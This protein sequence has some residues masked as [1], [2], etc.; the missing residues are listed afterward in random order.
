MNERNKKVYA[1]VIAVL[2]VLSIS[3]SFLP[4][5]PVIAS[6]NYSRV[7]IKSILD[8]AFYDALPSPDDLFSYTDLQ[9]NISAKINQDSSLEGVLK[10]VNYS[11]IRSY[12]ANFDEDTRIVQYTEWYNNHS[13]NTILNFSNDVIF[14]N[15]QD[16]FDRVKQI[17]VVIT[18]TDNACDLNWYL[19]L[20]DIY[21]GALGFSNPQ[22]Y[23]K[24]S[25]RLNGNNYNTDITVEMPYDYYSSQGTWF[26]P[27]ITSA[28]ISP[29]YTIYS[30][31]KIYLPY[32]ANFTSDPNI[33]SYDSLTSI[34]SIQSYLESSNQTEWG[35]K[36]C[37]DRR[38]LFS[39]FSDGSLTVDNDPISQ[40]YKGAW[41]IDLVPVDDLLDGSI[42]VKFVPTQKLS[43][44][45]PNYSVKYYFGFFFNGKKF[46][47]N[48]LIDKPLM[49]VGLSN[50]IYGNSNTT[51]KNITLNNYYNITDNDGISVNSIS[52]DYVSLPTSTVL[53]GLTPV[54]SYTLQGALVG[55]NLGQN[56]NPIN[57]Y[58]S[59]A[60]Y[61]SQNMFNQNNGGNNIGGSFGPISVGLSSNQGGLTSAK[62]I[63]QAQAFYNGSEASNVATVTYNYLT[64]E[65][66]KQGTVSS[67]NNTPV[68]SITGIPD[69]IT[70]QE[71]QA[72]DSSTQN[73]VTNG[74]SISGGNNT[75]SNTNNPTFT[76]NNNPSITINNNNGLTEPDGVPENPDEGSFSMLWSI[77]ESYHFAEWLNQDLEGNGFLHYIFSSQIW[78]LP[79]FNLI[80]PALAIL[81]T[82]SIAS[83]IIRFIRGN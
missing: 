72:I 9:D 73:I 61:K 48:S 71:Q 53:R 33:S 77:W 67:N 79:I 50:I 40:E 37:F 80:I 24:V 5:I 51:F 31:L 41:D 58:Q 38:T 69:G 1:I 28:I 70:P 54:G 25:V 45:N 46:N 15:Y 35:D 17:S 42:K 65:I 26:P 60:F 55:G 12:S 4:S 81:I 64:G 32:Q 23:I 2:L 34:S 83:T 36:F 29:S 20:D 44:D 76:N 7:N 10:N 14:D 43:T 11:L 62:L 19:F 49:N 3:T 18:T 56:S 74:G 78:D 68:D 47:Y 59:L 57:V 8:G 21:D 39:N 63:V 75:N 6:S 13:E 66:T 27:V 22:N 52:D 82:V 30:D 16:Y